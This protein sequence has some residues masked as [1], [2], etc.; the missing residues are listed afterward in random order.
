MNPKCK[1]SSKEYYNQGLRNLKVYL[2]NR[3][4]NLLSWQSF[5]VEPCMFKKLIF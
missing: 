1:A 4:A 3:S 2:K 5:A